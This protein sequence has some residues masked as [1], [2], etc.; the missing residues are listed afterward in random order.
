M[1]VRLIWHWLVLAF[2]LYVITLITPL[3]I[4]ADS[5]KDLLW[6]ALFLIVANTIIKP[7]LIVF[8]LPLVLLTLGLFLL[9]I[10]AVILDWIPYFVP[11]FHVHGFASAFFGALLLS[12][13]TGLFTGYERRNSIRRMNVAPRSDKVIDI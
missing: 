6:A 11:G 9:V 5:A 1:F 12:L 13:I 8:T 2:G 7:I 10:N 3:G 4:R